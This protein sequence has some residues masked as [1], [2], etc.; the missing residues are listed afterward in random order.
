M[1]TKIITITQGD[2]LGLLIS[3]DPRTTPEI[4]AAMGYH[5][6]TLPSLIRM[7]KLPSNAIERACR[8]FNVS[9]E[10]FDIGDLIATVQDIIR[11]NT[12]RDARARVEQAHNDL[13]RAQ[14]SALEARVKSLSEENLIL[15]K[16]TSN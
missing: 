6:K 12:L 14:V 9:P 8:T 4:A 15:K 16:P 3:K 5:H 1:A 2:V 11:D 10:V 7:N 13:L